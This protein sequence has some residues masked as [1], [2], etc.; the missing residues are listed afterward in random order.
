MTAR[1]SPAQ[2][3]LA[4]T[5]IRRGIGLHSGAWIECRLSPAEVGEGRLF[6]RRDLPGSP[7]IPAHLRQVSP[8]NLSTRLQQG[9][10]HIQTTEHLLAALAVLGIDNCRIEVDGPEIP[11]LDGSA[12]PWVEAILQ[13]G[14]RRQAA[15][16]VVVGIP[17]PITVC[18]GEAFISAL[19]S[20]GLRF[21]YGIDFADSPIGCQ[22]LS[23]NFSA[24]SFV[25]DLAPARTFTRQQDIE[26]A[27][28]AGLIKGG[29]LDNAIVC[30]AEGW[31]TPL[32]FDNEPVRHKLIDL[33]GDLSLLGVRLQGHILA[34][35]AGHTLHHQLAHQ[36]LAS[37]V[38]PSSD[39][40]PCFC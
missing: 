29:S 36:L 6:I 3:T 14:V 21:T 22:W 25:E 4:T 28:Q 23:W 13:A 35:R 11:I 15:L 27:Q 16:G 2:G 37:G 39:P 18:Q 32:R 17:S 26:K 24:E 5:I 20:P 10:A 30:H 31:L 8:A 12:L 9:S 19:P 7:V 38:L 40:Q 1:F 34:Y 33:L